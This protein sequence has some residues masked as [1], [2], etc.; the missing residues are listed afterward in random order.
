MRHAYGTLGD[1]LLIGQ[2]WGTFIDL[3]SYPDTV[4]FNP[5]ANNPLI[6]QPQIRVTLPVGPASLAIAAENPAQSGDLGGHGQAVA[7]GTAFEAIPDFVANLTV[8]MSFGHVSA[9][10]VTLNYKNLDRAKQG[11]GGAVSGSVKVAG[12]LVVW[13]AQAG[14]GIGR[15][16]FGALTSGQDA[17]ATATDIL[18]WDVLGY[19]VGY[20][21]V[22]S[23]QLRSNL[24]WSQTFFRNDEEIR[25]AVGADFGA[26]N[27]RIDQ[28][29]VNTFWTVT[30]TFQVGLE[31]AFGRRYTFAGDHGTENRINASAHF[32]IF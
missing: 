17:V 18:L 22:W 30:K 20:T 8:P 10:A 16:T 26:M 12:D 31:Y 21:H 5:P 11:I 32:N 28:G 24:I 14:H 19:H 13:Q 4:D 23:P 25:T 29:F 9:R 7:G 3:G 1:Y 27:Q 15:Y 6:R 2:S